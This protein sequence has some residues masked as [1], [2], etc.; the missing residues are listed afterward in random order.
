MYDV[1]VLH[2]CTEFSSDN[3]PCSLFTLISGGIFQ[4]IIV[5]LTVTKHLTPHNTSAGVH[6]RHLSQALIEKKHV[7]G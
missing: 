6:E 1:V 4:G 7:S 3:D 2:F 5:G